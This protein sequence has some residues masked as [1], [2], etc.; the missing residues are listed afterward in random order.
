MDPAPNAVVRVGEYEIDKVNVPTNTACTAP[1]SRRP[2]IAATSL[3]LP[4]RPHVLFC[5]V[6][7]CRAAG[8]PSCVLTDS[9]FH[10]CSPSRLFSPLLCVRE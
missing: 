3:P 2:C 10:H 9:Q 7:G 6:I 4:S 1:P 5:P 8:C